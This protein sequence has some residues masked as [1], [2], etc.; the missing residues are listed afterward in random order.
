MSSWII[1]CNPDY[2]DIERY[3]LDGNKT[4]FWVIKDEI[5]KEGDEVFLWRSQGR[6]KANKDN[7]GIIGRLMVVSD[8]ELPIDDEKYILDDN[9]KLESSY[10]YYKLEFLEVKLIKGQFIKRCCLKEHSFLKNIGPLKFT[11][12]TYYPLMRK[13]VN[14]LRRIWGNIE[15]LEECV[16]CKKGL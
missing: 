12:N 4:I 16:N 13:E 6:R 9:K 1:Q 5:L 15:Q 2:Y 10:S 14:E 11:Q 7:S 3:I 8:N